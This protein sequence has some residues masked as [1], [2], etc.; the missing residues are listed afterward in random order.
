MP[1]IDRNNNNA[2]YHP[3]KFDSDNFQGLKNINT[4][5]VY[6]LWY[7]FGGHENANDYSGSHTTEINLT[8]FDPE[9]KLQNLD[10]LFANCADLETLTLPK[11][12]GTNCKSMSHTFFNC[13]ALTGDYLCNALN[14]LVTTN[15]KDM[16]YMF[17]SY[18]YYLTTKIEPSDSITLLFPTSFSFGNELSTVEG[19]FAGYT[20][21]KKLI[22]T[23]NEEGLNKFS[24]SD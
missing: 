2:L 4:E 9:N 11:Q 24:P 3:F 16:S 6:N 12:F 18:K 17:A 23:N 8:D 10:G 21:T 5:S 22:I 15:V 1:A 19:M 13:R 7:M 14:N 20:N